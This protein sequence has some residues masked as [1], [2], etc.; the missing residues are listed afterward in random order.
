MIIDNKFSLKNNNKTNNNTKI[1]KTYYN[2]ITDLA[3]NKK[4][5]F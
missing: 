3:I 1:Y 2:S 5:V 4:I